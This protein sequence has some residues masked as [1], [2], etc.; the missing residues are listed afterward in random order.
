MCGAD[1]VDGDEQRQAQHGLRVAEK[2]VGEG[3]REDRDEHHPR[4]EP[5]HREQAAEHYDEYAAEHVA[6]ARADGDGR[7][8]EL[9]ER[10]RRDDGGE[11]D[12]G[13]D[14]VDPPQP[15]RRP[16]PPPHPEHASR[17]P[18]PPASA[19]GMT[20][21]LTPQRRPSGVSGKPRSGH[22]VSGKWLS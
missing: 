7:A 13:R 16:G 18:G 22:L 14:G 10:Q 20:S 9:R 5:A 8:G 17:G 2:H 1:R 4:A 19:R 12:V 15:A 6:R 21:A 11:H 3:H